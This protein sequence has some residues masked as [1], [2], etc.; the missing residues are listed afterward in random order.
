MPLVRDLIEPHIKCK[1]ELLLTWW[2]PFL[3]ASTAPNQSLQHPWAP[4][5]LSDSLGVMAIL[6]AKP[7]I[8]PGASLQAWCQL[9]KAG[10]PFTDAVC[11]PALVEVS[12]NSIDACTLQAWAGLYIRKPIPK[13]ISEEQLKPFIAKVQADASL[14]EEL[15]AEGADPVA[16]AKAAWFA[17]STE[18]LKAH[19]QDLSQRELESVAGATCDILTAIVW[20]S[21]MGTCFICGK[22]KIR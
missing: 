8:S 17:I 13:Q 21:Y 19:R 7:L 2:D 14:Q 20:D 5:A 1:W 9:Q 18:D 3:L 22:N 12:S 11:Y 6:L 16:I 10:V 15:K 4:M